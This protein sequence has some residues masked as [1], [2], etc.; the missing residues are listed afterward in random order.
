MIKNRMIKK[1]VF[2]L[3][4]AA[5]VMLSVPAMANTYE[6]GQDPKWNVVFD[7]NKDMVS[8]FHSRDFDEVMNGLQ[9]GDDAV[10]YISV[11][12]TN[13]TTTDWY[14]ENKILKSLAERE[15]KAKE[16]DKGAY[17]YYLSYKDKN[18]KVTEFYNSDTVGGDN[19]PGGDRKGLKE[20]TG[21]LENYFYLDTLK[22]GEGGMLTLRVAL[23]GETQGNSYQDTLA[24]L[25]LDFA[26]ELNET[27]TPPQNHKNISKSKVV[28]TGDTNMIPYAVAGG[29]AGIILLLLAVFGAKRRKKEQA[30]ANKV[31]RRGEGAKR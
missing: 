31:T 20:A 11:E 21:A 16:T 25:Q 7:Q 2:G 13:S 15:A 3:A 27:G 17:T 22:K 12:N 4:L 9:P 18:G 14:M 1:S 8:N 26:V 30:V 23:D 6:R 5:A 28:K 29:I 24:Q 10:F 19:S